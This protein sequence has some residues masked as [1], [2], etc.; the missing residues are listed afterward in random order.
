MDRC[1]TAVI[2]C[3]AWWLW[4]LL[5]GWLRM[6]FDSIVPGFAVHGTWNAVAVA[7]TWAGMFVVMSW[8]S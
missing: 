8:F 5:F 2:A 1:E 7:R 3:L 6:R 4:G